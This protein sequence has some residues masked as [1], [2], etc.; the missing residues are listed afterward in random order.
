[1]TDP[2]AW[3]R[4]FDASH[5][6]ISAFEHDDV[7]LIGVE[8]YL[9]PER[10]VSLVR[11]ADNPQSLFGVGTPPTRYTLTCF[12]GRT[13]TMSIQGTDEPSGVLTRVGKILVSHGCL[14]P[15]V[16]P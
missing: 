15:K 3:H 2:R 12:C 6:Q 1:M 4:A 14:K 16:K 13:R 10:P 9:A 5:V 7:G 11:W 8:F